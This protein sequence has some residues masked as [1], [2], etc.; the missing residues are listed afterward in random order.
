MRQ[1]VLD[2]G[3]H[4]RALEILYTKLNI[5]LE[6]ESDFENVQNSVMH[7]VLEL[8]PKSH[9]PYFGMAIPH[10]FLG[11]DV[12]ETKKLSEGKDSFTLKLYFKLSNPNSKKPQKITNALIIKE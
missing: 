6:S 11:L 1:L 12:E 8:Y 9:S 4:C 3:G 7:K 10:S 2:V 5:K